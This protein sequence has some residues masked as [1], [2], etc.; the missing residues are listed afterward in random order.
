MGARWALYACWMTAASV[1]LALVLSNQLGG[2][3]WVWVPPVALL[4]L[5]LRHLGTLIDAWALER[6][7]RRARS[8]T[9]GALEER[10]ASLPYLEHHAEADA[11][12]AL[13][14]LL[15]DRRHAEVIANWPRHAAALAAVGRRGTGYEE[16]DG[17]LELELRVS[18]EVLAERMSEPAA[19]VTAL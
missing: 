1:T 7:R 4:F 3:L 5:A 9:S 17:A 10:L 18:I 8:Q 19:S 13:R 15:S 14:A 12:R 2:S 11:V 6:A 16:F